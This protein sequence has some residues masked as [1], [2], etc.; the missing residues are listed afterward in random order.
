MTSTVS[1]VMPSQ[2]SSA[3]LQLS[4]AGGVAP[5][6]A[7]Q[8]AIPAMSTHQQQGDEGRDLASV[9]ASLIRLSVGGEH[10]DDVIADLDQALGRSLSF[11]TAYRVGAGVGHTG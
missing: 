8:P 1:S 7:P 9:P 5:A 11:A 10:P 4:V 6:Q 2:S 3:P